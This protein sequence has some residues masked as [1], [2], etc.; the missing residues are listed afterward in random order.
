MLQ[1]PKADESMMVMAGLLTYS[2]LAAF[3]CAAAE[4]GMEYQVLLYVKLEFT[5]SQLI[6]SPA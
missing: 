5:G 1:S 2:F 6:A 3:P 4:S